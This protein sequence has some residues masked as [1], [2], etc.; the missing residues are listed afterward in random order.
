MAMSYYAKEANPLWE[1]YSTKVVAHTLHS[2]SR[3]TFDYPYPVAI[4]V[5]ASNGMEYPMICFNY[6]RPEKDGTYSEAIK[7]GM[8]SVIIH[9]VGHNYFPMI[10]NSDERQWSWMDEGLNTFLQFLAEQEWDR[11]YPSRRGPAYRIAEYMKSDPLTLEPIMTN[12][13]NIIQFGPNAYAKPATALNILRET[14]MGRE[15]FDHAFKTYSQ[16]WMFKHPTPEDFFRTMEDASGVDLDWFWRGWFYGTDPVD[17]SIEDVR[18]FKIDNR[19]YE[20]KVADDR[21][22]YMED[23]DYLS[24]RRNV[25]DIPETY[26]ERDPTT[27][28]F[29]NTF[30]RFEIYEDEDEAEAYNKKREGLSD[31]QK[32]WA[33]KDL[34]FYEMK[35]KNN[36]GLVMPVIVQFEFEDGNSQTEYLPAEIWRLNEEEF[37]KVFAFDKEVVRF[38]LDPYRETADIDE[39]N[40]HWPRQIKM[41]RFEQ[42][43]SGG[44]RRG[45]SR[46]ENPMQKQ[47]K[48]ERKQSAEE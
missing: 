18:A 44:F 34:Y 21:K 13:E 7:N 14:I 47:R 31:R 9:E 2:Y 32:K 25:K 20:E 46:G 36:G 30:D 27:V 45:M 38:T 4:S 26:I 10:V 41:N 12:S 43:N 16:R 3:F 33:E 48:R 29:Y 19:S 5:E 23:E 22:A 15:L 8:I 17:I 40:N 37:S 6:G 11:N 24:R 28:D 42:F 1:Q 35:F 39:Y